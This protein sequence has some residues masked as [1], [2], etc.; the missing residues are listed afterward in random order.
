MLLGLS[1]RRP[2]RLPA[3]KALPPGHRGLDVPRLHLHR[4]AQSARALGCDELRARTGERQVDRL[5]IEKGPGSPGVT[6][7]PTRPA[8]GRAP[9]G[10]AALSSCGS[11]PAWSAARARTRFRVK[12][13]PRAT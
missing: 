11:D 7:L 1:S 3:A 6:P 2:P 9:A 10:P 13:S 4:V 5:E 8:A 12:P